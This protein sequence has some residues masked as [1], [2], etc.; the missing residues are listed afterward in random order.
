MQGVAH[1]LCSGSV[2]GVPSA[3][4]KA[5]PENTGPAG[6][7]PASQHLHVYVCVHV[8]MYDWICVRNHGLGCSVV[9]GN[10][11]LGI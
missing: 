7:L 11:D 2:C 5:G 6:R 10:V 3:D 9:S 8:L 4:R 1:G